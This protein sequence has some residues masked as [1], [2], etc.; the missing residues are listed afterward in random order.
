MRNENRNRKQHKNKKWKSKIRNR[1]FDFKHLEFETFDIRIGFLV[2][3]HLRWYFFHLQ[4]PIFHQISMH[5][6]IYFIIGGGGRRRAGGFLN[7]NLTVSTL[8]DGRCEVQWHI[9]L[10]L[11][12][13]AGAFYTATPPCYPSGSFP[14]RRLPPPAG[15]RVQGLGFRV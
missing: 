8:R 13:F 9:R 10:T 6:K 2:K 3:F 12:R 15:F 14:L 7:N 11:K 4:T 1:N 5:L